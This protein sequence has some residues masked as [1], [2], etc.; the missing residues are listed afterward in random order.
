[1][2]DQLQFDAGAHVY[3][4]R[5]KRVPSVTQILR[6]I[7]NFDGV[8]PDVLAAAAEFGTHAH[9]A[10]D[11]YNRGELDE[12][13]LDPALAPYLAQWKA[14]IEECDLTIENSELRVLHPSGHYA[15][16]I[17]VM[18][19]INGKPFLADIKTG[20]TMPAS[21]GPQT[22]AYHAALEDFDRGARRYCIHL[23]P[24]RY[25]MIRLTDKTDIHIFQSCLNIWR[26]N[27]A[28]P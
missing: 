5:G 7:I 26:F 4:V 15:G 6:P 19:R 11:L 10:C 21:V 23:M 9:M 14:C 3:S 25:K 28:H 24:D 1:L 22:A 27:N 8:P 12:A 13:S 16:T 17:D 18:G 2:A 20:S